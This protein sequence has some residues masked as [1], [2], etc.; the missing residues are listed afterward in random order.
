MPAQMENQNLAQLLQAS[1]AGAE[2]P[3][4]GTN[5]MANSLAALFAGGKQK[6]GGGLGGLLGAAG[7]IFSG[8][9]SLFS[10]GFGGGMGGIGG[11]GFG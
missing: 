3:Y 7:S 1:G 10:G 9:G 8:A 4:A 6:S 11:T 2:L 5:S